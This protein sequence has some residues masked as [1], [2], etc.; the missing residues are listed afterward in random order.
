MT[1]MAQPF[2][3]HGGMPPGHP[4]LPHG[5]PMAGQHPGAPHMGGQPN[6]GM[7][8]SMHPGVSGPQVTGPMVTGMPPGAGT[9]APGGPVQNAHAMAH[10]NPGQQPMFQQGHPQMNRKFIFPFVDFPC[11]NCSGFSTTPANYLFAPPAIP[12]CS[13]EAESP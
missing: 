13:Y 7:M 12:W 6:P 2:P 9:V 10:L 5:H 11:T 1:Q 3:T 4:G 8:H